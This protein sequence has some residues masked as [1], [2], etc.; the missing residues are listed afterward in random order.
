MKLHTDLREYGY[1]DDTSLSS[2]CDQIKEYLDEKM[3]STSK[4]T[5]TIKETITDSM[6]TY[7]EKFCC[8]NC[9][10]ERAKKEIINK[11]DNQGSGSGCCCKLATKEDVKN[12]IEEINEHTDSKFDEMN[13]NQQ[14][15]DLNQQ[16]REIKN[17]LG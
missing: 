9:H 11:I 17:K 12:A 3:G 8:T 13:F 16:V 14:F 1:M 5:D 7:D 6:S 2:R 10:I 15:S 4:I